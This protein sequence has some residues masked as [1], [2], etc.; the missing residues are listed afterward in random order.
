MLLCYQTIAKPLKHCSV[1]YGGCDRWRSVLLSIEIFSYYRSTTTYSPYIFSGTTVRPVANCHQRNKQTS[2][3][4]AVD[5]NPGGFDISG[6]LLARKRNKH[7]TQRTSPNAIALG[8]DCPSPHPSAAAQAARHR[9]R[10]WWVRLRS[11][12]RLLSNCAACG[13]SF[14]RSRFATCRWKRVAF[15]VRAGYRDVLR[16]P[17]ARFQRFRGGRFLFYQMFKTSFSGRNTIWEA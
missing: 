16:R 6:G 2:N 7:R 8:S 11:T 3:T 5:S 15:V 12:R 17:L 1:K 14:V 13:G 4:N 10:R 9:K